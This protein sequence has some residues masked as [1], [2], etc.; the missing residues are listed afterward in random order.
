MKRLFAA[1][2]IQPSPEFLNLL[3][4]LKRELH[5]EKI[6]WVSPENIHITLKFYGETP[7]DD[8]PLIEKV[9]QEAAVAHAPFTFRLKGLG[10]FGSSYR[11]RVIWA[12]IEDG[13][14]LAELGKAVLN[15][16]DRAGWKRDRQNFVPHLTI[17][18][19]KQ[20]E[21]KRHFQEVI[22]KD[23]DVFLQEVSAEEIILY[24][25]IL[26]SQGPEYVTL[27]SFSLGG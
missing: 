25:S 11:P 12:G 3:F 24:E 15:G 19:I 17:G 1:I 16:S 8:I 14:P 23:R 21:D 5:Y 2:K 18:R 22:R 4:H 6:K 20:L 26:R 27:G 10:V 7:E 13:K 9:L